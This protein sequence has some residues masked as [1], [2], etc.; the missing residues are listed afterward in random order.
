MH[1]DTQLITHSSHGLCNIFCKCRGWKIQ[2][3]HYWRAPLLGWGRCL[4]CLTE[5]NF[6]EQVRP[7]RQQ[8]VS[9]QLKA[10]SVWYDGDYPDHDRKAHL[11]TA[12]PLVVGV[13]LNSRRPGLVSPTEILL[14]NFIS[15]SE[16]QP[17]RGEGEVWGWVWPC[18]GRKRRSSGVISSYVGVG[19][20]NTS[21]AVLGPSRGPTVRQ[22]TSLHC[23][24]QCQVT[25][26]LTKY[27]PDLGLL[28][29]SPH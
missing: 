22:W 18:E 23:S 2:S 15:H 11:A 27:Q 16:L 6:E 9:Q 29:T 26:G 14:Q 3:L 8:P 20:L 24:V 17:R 5:Q 28:N 12:E 25:A 13:S 7:H 19:L 1:T 21:V 4:L 10:F